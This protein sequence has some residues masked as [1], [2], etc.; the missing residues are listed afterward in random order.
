M[1]ST[2]VKL[3]VITAAVV[4][5][6]HSSSAQSKMP[7]RSRPLPDAIRMDVVIHKVPP[8]YPFQARRSRLTGGGIL[9]GA[10]NIKTGYVVSVRMEKSTGHKILD[11]AALD[12]FRQWRFKPGTTRKFRVPINYTMH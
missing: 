2:L 4:I 5:T 8:E 9:V 11:A 10:V 1:P 7:S 6:A 3:A 12:A